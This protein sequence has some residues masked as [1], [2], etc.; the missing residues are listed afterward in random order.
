MVARHETRGF[1]GFLGRV[2]GTGRD[3]VVEFKSSPCLPAGSLDC[4]PAIRLSGGGHLARF[5]GLLSLLRLLSCSSISRLWWC[6]A[7][8]HFVLHAQ[9]AQ[10]HF[11][12]RHPFAGLVLR[13]AL[14][15]DC[16]DCL[17]S[18]RVRIDNYFGLILARIVYRVVR[19]YWMSSYFHSLSVRSGG[20]TILS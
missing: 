8:M 11:G 1:W 14:W 5:Y 20:A 12:P 10:W 18:L 9:Q 17:S 16:C 6:N 3:A 7:N 13:S 4:W 19:P 15:K 2:P